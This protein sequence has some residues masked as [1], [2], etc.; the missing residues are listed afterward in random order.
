M[1]SSAEFDPTG[2]YRY[3]LTRRWAP[4]PS[5]LFIG[6]NPSTADAEKD[7]NTIRKEIHYARTW[8]FGCLEKANM[9]AYRSTDP[10]KLYEVED[11]MGPDNAAFITRMAGESD[12][13]ICA[14]GCEKLAQ[15]NHDRTMDLLRSVGKPLHCLSVTKAG[16]PGHPLYLKKSLLAV[17]YEFKV[18]DLP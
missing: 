11:P 18:G 13:I 5:C 17:L 16:Y 10:K 7:D 15:E 3:R 14:W 8:G 9:F 12:M 1:E 4:G 2:L 6:L